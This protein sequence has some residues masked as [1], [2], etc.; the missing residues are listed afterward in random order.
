MQKCNIND[1]DTIYGSWDINCDRKIF[2]SSWAIFCHFTPPH[3]PPPP[4]TARKMKIS[5]KW[6]QHLVISSF[7][8]SAPKLMIIGYTVLEMWHGTD[9]II[10]FILGNFLPFYPP[11]PNTQKNENFKKIKKNP[12]DIIILH[13]SIPKL[14]NICYTVPEICCV[15]E[16][17]V[18]FHFGLFFPLL[19]L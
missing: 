9:M 1:H 13:K 2:L 4:L 18:I 3:T 14:M 15:M 11:P 17:I 6:K 19:P 8:T 12:R 10:V 7:Y 16:I 5:K